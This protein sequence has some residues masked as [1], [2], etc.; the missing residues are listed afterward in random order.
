MCSARPVQ[1]A[2]AEGGAAARLT[3]DA[4]KSLE[5]YH[6]SLTACRHRVSAGSFGAPRASRS[7]GLAPK[8]GP[9]PIRHRHHPSRDPEVL[10]L[11]LWCRTANLAS[12]LAGV[13]ACGPCKR[14]TAASILNGS[15]E[16]FASPG[17]VRAPARRSGWTLP[18]NRQCKPVRDADDARAR[19]QAR[20]LLQTGL[21]IRRFKLPT[22]T[23]TP[24]VGRLR[25]KWSIAMVSPNRA[26]DPAVDR[27]TA[28]ANAKQTM[29]R[30][31][32][33][34]RNR[35]RRCDCNKDSRRTAWGGKCRQD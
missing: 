3:P 10:L 24:L 14:V 30:S 6:A 15:A 13:S 34:R 2:A 11:R 19:Q 12:L 18:S 27:D 5:I 23:L 33:G 35:P 4:A 26:D 25:L 21:S 16:L 29:R 31:Q 28:A 20:A 17:K 9:F 22:S 1:D 7:F 32:S 8:P